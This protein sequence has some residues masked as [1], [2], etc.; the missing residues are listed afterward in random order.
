MNDAP[1]LSLETNIDSYRAEEPWVNL[2]FLSLFHGN[3]SKILL[4]AGLSSELKGYL[5]ILPLHNV[6]LH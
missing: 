4:W 6:L 2:L 5:I 1:C 3:K